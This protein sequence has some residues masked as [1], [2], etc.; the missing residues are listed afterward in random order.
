MSTTTTTT[1]EHDDER[2]ERGD[3]TAARVAPADVRFDTSDYK[4]SN[5]GCLPRLSVYG[6]WAFC[7]VDPRRADYL[8]HVL[9]ESGTYRDARAAARRRA[10]ALGVTLL[11]VC[12]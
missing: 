5:H 7:T 11:W 9:W 3:E 6:S 8:D 12:A 2:H 4:R 1:N 10:A